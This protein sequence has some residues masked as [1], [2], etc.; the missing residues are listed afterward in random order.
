MIQVRAPKRSL[1]GI[2]MAIFGTL[3]LAG[4]GILWNFQGREYGLTGTITSILALVFGFLFL[5]PLQQA[6]VKTQTLSN[7]TDKDTDNIQEDNE[8]N[9]EL[10][11]NDEDMAKNKIE[12]TTAESIARELQESL[13]SMPAVELTNFSCTHL[14]PGQTINTKLRK[15]GPSIQK[16]R[17]MVK[18]IF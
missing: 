2:V 18:D 9:D 8:V 7:N 13:K 12:E 10:S 11:M 17:T 5:W 16:Y 15:P 14:L 6:V 3:G 1:I 4:S